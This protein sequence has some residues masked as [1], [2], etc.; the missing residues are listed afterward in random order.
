MEDKIKEA[1]EI[2]IDRI[3]TIL[4]SGREISAETFIGIANIVVALDKENDVPIST[5]I[6]EETI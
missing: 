5:L 2:I 6:E 4:K 1:K 3:Y